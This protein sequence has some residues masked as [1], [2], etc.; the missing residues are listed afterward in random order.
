MIIRSNSWS[1]TGSLIEKQ[2]WDI[3]EHFWDNWGNVNVDCILES[4][5]R[6]MLNLFG[7]T[8]CYGYVGK[9]C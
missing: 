6:K 5:I 8:Q 1:L 3:E 9:C 7:M 4:G 2:N